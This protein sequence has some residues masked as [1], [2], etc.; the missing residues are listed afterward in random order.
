MELDES[1]VETRYIEL[2]DGAAN[3]GLR[4]AGDETDQRTRVANRLL[5]EKL[6]EKLLGMATVTDVEVKAGD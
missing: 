6:R 2:R 4:L 3:A 1:E 5:Q